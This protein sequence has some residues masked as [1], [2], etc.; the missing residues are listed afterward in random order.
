MTPEQSMRMYLTE[1]ALHAEVLEEGLR[2]TSPIDLQN[3]KTRWAR[4]FYP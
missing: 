4:R 1:C 3:C 2:D